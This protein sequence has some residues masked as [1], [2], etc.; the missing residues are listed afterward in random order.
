MSIFEERI[1]Q[2]LDNRYRLTLLTES[3][4]RQAICGPAEL[5]GIGLEEELVLTLLSELSEEG[6]DP[7]Q[8]QIV[9]DRLYTHRDPATNRITLATYERL[10]GVRRIL[11][12]YLQS[13]LAEGLGAFGEMARRVLSVLVTPRGTKAVLSLAEIAS[14]LGDDAPRV[15]DVVLMLVNA[16]LV[17]ELTQDGDHLFELAHEYIIQ[18][19][20]SWVS[21]A[22]L[23]LK[24]ARLVLRS[25]LD[26]WQRF[27]SLMGSDRLAILE[28]EAEKLQPSAEEQAL[29]LWA[30][31]VHRRAID[32]W[33]GGVKTQPRGLSVLVKLLAEEQL[34][35]WC[36][37]RALETLFVVPLDDESAEALLH[38]AQRFGNPSL[39]A[40]LSKLCPRSPQPRLLQAIQVRVHRR[41]FGSSRMVHVPAGPAIIGSTAENKAERKVRV[42]LDL[43]A[44]IDT[45]PDRCQVQVDEFWI[46]RYLVTNDEFAEFKPDHV[47]RYPQSEANHPAVY[48]SWYDAVGFARWLGK[49]LP[50]EV[51]WEKAARGVAGLIY[52]WGNDFDPARLNSAESELRRTTPVLA[53][54]QGASPYG[55]LDMAGN[56]WEWTSSPWAPD[57][58]HKAQKGGSTVSFEPHQQC[59][60]RYEGY[61]DFI[62]SFVGFRSVCRKRPPM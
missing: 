20:N 5:F 44:R 54:T 59:S 18:E 17:R 46:D 12:G 58:P 1:P 51:E 34:T 9:C 37:R 32:P 31:V 29:L 43:Q 28:P 25:E 61:P 45:E 38:A 55:C 41:F 26:N 10:G 7:P 50:T 57:D 35:G 40:S 11:V 24:H 23:S 47:H 13:T 19:V 15:R 62:L 60:A 56:V 4:A 39:L 33:L 2:I 16:R 22:E 30:A 42:R 8:L 36:A 21:D 49:D 27:G 48:V 14:S 52:P 6:I 53:Y 3:Q